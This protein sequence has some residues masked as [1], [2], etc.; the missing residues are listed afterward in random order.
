M[1][2]I[3]D[4]ARDSQ[5]LDDVELQRLLDH[6]QLLLGLD[7]LP[8]MIECVRDR[9]RHD[10]MLDLTGGDA[11]AL[12]EIRATLERIAAQ[13]APDFAGALELAYYRDQLAARNARIPVDLPAVWA[14]LGQVPRAEALA[15]SLSEPEQRARALASIAAALAEIERYQAAGEAALQADAVAQ[16]I[17]DHYEQAG[18]LVEVSQ[19]LAGSGNHE[20]AREVAAQAGTVAQLIRDAELQVRALACEALALAGAGQPEQS[21]TAARQAESVARSAPDAYERASALVAIAKI[22]AEKGQRQEAATAADQ[23][24]EATQLVINPN[25]R[26]G[27]LAGAVR[28]FAE[29]G[30]Q[31][32]AVFVAAQAQAMSRSLTR[33]D[34]QAYAMVEV[35]GALAEA[36]QYQRAE[37]VARSIAEPDQQAWALAKVASALADDG[38]CEQA[39]ALAKS[40]ADPYPQAIGL[41]SVARALSRGGNRERAVAV[42]ARAEAMLRSANGPAAPVDDVVRVAQALARNGHRQQATALAALASKLGGSVGWSG[43]S[44]SLASPQSGSGQPGREL[45]IEEAEASALS[46][47]DVFARVRA[48]TAVAAALDKGGQRQRA[49]RLAARA[50]E[51][52]RSA[53]DPATQVNSLLEVA[54]ALDRLGE[55]PLAVSIAIEAEAIGRSVADFYIGANLMAQFMAVGM[56]MFLL[57]NVADVLATIGEHS[58]A[59][60]IASYLRDFPNSRELA[61]TRIVSALA[62]TGQLREAEAVARSIVDPVPRGNALATVATA[63]AQSGDEGAAARIAAELCVI[64]NWRALAELMAWIEPSATTGLIRAL[65]AQE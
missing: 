28:A 16:T 7:D 49:L 2:W 36:K 3:D 20:R 23:A 21:Q 5:R 15:R 38:R 14:G 37:T 35:T 17:T 46:I 39:E 19:A 11:A 55:R 9:A 63:L 25:Q 40:I 57:I 6:F 48:L 51:A 24:I 56:Q 12:M 64:G 65:K 44:G 10:R 60:E 53:E 42:A 4:G 13:D 27:I 62:A 22:M 54:Q 61:S 52:A 43:D 26:I 50:E 8:G 33:P 59:R 41:V 47:A 30:Q 31:E 45:T 18:A 58:R 29:A 34:E 32:R 1:M